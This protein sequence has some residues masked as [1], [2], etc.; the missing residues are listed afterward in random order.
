MHILSIETSCDETAVSVIEARGDFPRATYRIIGNALFSQVDIHREY[1]GVFPNVAKREH[2]RTIVPMFERAL[3]EAGLLIPRTTPLSLSADLSEL[4]RREEGLAEALTDFFRTYEFPQIDLIAVTSGPGL[5]PAL[6]VG[7]NFAK[8][9]GTIGHIPVVPVNH[10]EGHVLASIFDGDRLPDILFPA[11]SLLISGGHTELERMRDWHTYELLGA[12][13]DDAVGEAFDKVARML[14]LPYPGGPEISRLARAAR[15]KKLPQFAK[16]PRPMIDTDDF[17]FSFSGLKTAVRY[18]IEK[19][20]PSD[21]QKEALS[22]DFE[23]A[24]TEVLL[25]K[26]ARAVSEQGAKTLILGGGVTANRHIREAFALFFKAEFPDVALFVPE[27]KL[28]TD[29]SIMIALAGHAR[30]AEGRMSDTAIAEIKAD[31][32]RKLS[33]S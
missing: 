22:R 5:E 3:K 16:L 4:L 8:A 13:R 30:A 26:T 18:T 21:E 2:T 23:D 28:S 24:V 12:T 19:N 6:W 1:G 33:A 14:G 11:V 29:N 10:M 7:V 27:P 20:E 25:A 32:N 9:L 31:G 17:D 15:E